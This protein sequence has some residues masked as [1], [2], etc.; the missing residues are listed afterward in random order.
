MKIEKLNTFDLPDRVIKQD[1]YDTK[2][3]PD[4]SVDNIVV[5]MEKINE[6]VDA[7]NNLAGNNR[8]FDEFDR[9]NIEDKNAIDLANKIQYLYYQLPEC[10][11]KTFMSEWFG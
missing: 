5:Y 3:F 7:V 2:S 1:G 9:S 11:L 6:L 4:V 8:L 10:K